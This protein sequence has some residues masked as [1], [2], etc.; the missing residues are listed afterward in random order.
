[1]SSTLNIPRYLCISPK[2]RIIAVNTCI[3]I[4]TTYNS[5]IHYCIY[6]LEIHRNDPYLQADGHD[7]QLLASECLGVQLQEGTYFLPLLGGLCQESQVIS[8]VLSGISR[9]HKMLIH[10]QLELSSTKWDEAPSAKSN[11]GSIELGIAHFHPFP[12]TSVR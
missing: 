7:L 8:Q 1:M 6:Y 10:L 3:Y 4:Y 11:F 9:V 12:G 5:S 2:S